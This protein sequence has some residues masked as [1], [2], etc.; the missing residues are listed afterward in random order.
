MTLKSRLQMRARQLK[1]ELTAVYYACR[2]PRMPRLPK[3][4]AGIALGYALS[5][6]DLIPDFIP[7]LGYLDDLIILPLLIALA[8]KM[9]PSEIMDHAR[10]TALR[11]PLKLPHNRLA[12]ALIITLWVLVL[13]AAGYLIFL[14]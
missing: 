14:R 7:I 3:F 10:E 9:I 6:I 4:I 8:I 11:N 2:D 1:H 12:A 5:P 13:F